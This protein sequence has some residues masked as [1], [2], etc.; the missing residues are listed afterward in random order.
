MIAFERRLNL[1][2]SLPGH[3]EWKDRQAVERFSHMSKL[4][5]SGRRGV[6]RGYV[7]ESKVPPDMTGEQH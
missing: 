3:S 6:M 4:R 7:P 2:V 1:H 5:F